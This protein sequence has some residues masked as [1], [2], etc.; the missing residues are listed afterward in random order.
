MVVNKMVSYFLYNKVKVSANLETNIFRELS[1][2]ILFFCILRKTIPEWE[3]CD[4]LRNLWQKNLQTRPNYAY[5]AFI[6]IIFV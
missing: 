3:T 6:D 1:G 5:F 2:L 4:K